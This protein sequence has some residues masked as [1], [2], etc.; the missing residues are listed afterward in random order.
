VKRISILLVAVSL[1]L[2]MPAAATAQLGPTN[3]PAPLTQPDDTA[4]T[5]PFEEDTG[6][7]TLQLVLMF[8]GAIAIV[9]RRPSRGAGDRPRPRGRGRGRRRRR[10]QEVG[11]RTRARAGAQARQGEGR[12]QPAQ[13]QPPALTAPGTAGR[14][15]KLARA[16]ALARAGYAH[17]SQS[18][19]G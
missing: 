3:V 10:A 13:A 17:R 11:A 6:L 16:H 4:D 9:A 19:G 12:A 15:T 2:A 7:S 8:G 1:G 5:T 18:S 14:T